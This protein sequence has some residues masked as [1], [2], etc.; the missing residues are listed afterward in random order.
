MTDRF[1]DR[2]FDLLGR[3]MDKPC[4]RSIREQ[5]EAYQE[6]REAYAVT[7]AWADGVRA[8]LF[9]AGRVKVFKKPTNQRNVFTAYNWARIYPNENAPE[10]LAY[11]V[12]I[13]A[14]HGFQVKIDTVHLGDR[15]RVRSAY[16]TLRGDFSNESPIVRLLPKAEGLD[17][18]LPELV[19]WTVEAIRG[20][21]LRY[22]EVV[23]HLEQAELPDENLLRHF[24]GDATFRAARL[25]WSPEQRALFC[26]LA[27]AVHAAG[28]DW[29]HTRKDTQVAFGR[30]EPGSK[31]AAG[32]LGKVQTQGDMT[33]SLKRP[34]G[35]IGPHGRRTLA[36]GVVD[37]LKAE[38]DGGRS[39][40]ADWRLERDGLWP[41]A[42]K[43]TPTD[44][45]DDAG[46]GGFGTGRAP[47]G[48]PIN[49]IYY[50]PPGT[51]KT[52]EVSKLLEREYQDGDARRYTFVTFHQSYGYEEFIEGLRPVLD[53]EFDTGQVRYE[54]RAGA[55]RQLCNQA[56]EEPD[57][58]YALVVDEINRGNV[59]KIFGELITLIEPDK[60]EGGAN[61]LAVTLP[62]SG[63]R[64]SVPANVDIIGTMNTADRSLALLDTALRRRFEFVPVL[65]DA[66]DAVGAPLAGLRVTV[67]EQ[68]I[69]VPRMLS[70][71]NRRIEILYDRDHC[72]GH[73]YFMGLQE[74]E[75]GQERMTA[76]AQVFEK[77][78]VPLLEEYFFEG[79]NNIRLVLADNRK[80]EPAQF[81]LDATA[82]EGDLERLLG[83]EHGVDG[84]AAGRLFRVQ[85]EAYRNPQAYI[86]IYDVP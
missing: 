39:L 14:V 71:M 4:D 73:A 58:R 16:V 44:V 22:D 57:A 9:P 12:G 69:D 37:Q 15:D 38:L 18:T 62:Y 60:R 34:L 48:A 46:L 53:E 76:L 54:I 50:G 67:G 70:A 49:R 72:I 47:V 10:M 7:E 68:T 13:S 17:K 19:E 3:W 27:R 25:A 1:T 59:S 86:G 81:I 61:A 32:L 66:R 8:S 29:W 82:D 20:F 41:D 75:N 77:N 79:W 26:R 85:A 42:W 55:F 6:L 21:E 80:P 24:D 43:N 78:V 83:E 30:S 63:K 5:D 11:T 65:P 52:Y 74:K 35:A 36:V 33:F 31:R 2:H 56:R 51:G 23:D 28:L 64:F 84:D 45:G 40:P